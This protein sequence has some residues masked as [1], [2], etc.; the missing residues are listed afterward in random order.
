MSIEHILY[1]TQNDSLRSIQG[2]TLESRNIISMLSVIKGY[3]IKASSIDVLNIIFLNYINIY[4][5]S[6]LE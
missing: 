5:A 2:E 4:A 6:I 1:T 3:S